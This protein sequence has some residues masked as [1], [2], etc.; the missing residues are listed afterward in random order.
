M[1]LTQD[2]AEL[3]NKVLPKSF[4]AQRAMVAGMRMKSAPS[5]GAPGKTGTVRTIGA[6]VTSLNGV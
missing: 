5:E 2:R 3:C 6:D 1:T 4:K